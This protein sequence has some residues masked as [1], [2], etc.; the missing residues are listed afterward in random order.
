MLSVV[1][2]SV[3]AGG[4]TGVANQIHQI[5][6]AFQR[7]NVKHAQKNILHQS[8]REDPKEALTDNNGTSATDSVRPDNESHPEA[9]KSAERIAAA[10]LRCMKCYFFTTKV[11]KPMQ[12]SKYFADLYP[13]V[14]SIRKSQKKML[15][16]VQTL[17]IEPK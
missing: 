15:I 17:N 6:E 2:A 16:F 13:K 9:S 1:E 8:R 5:V 14:E 4:P 10:N 12:I 7:T 11:L 3:A